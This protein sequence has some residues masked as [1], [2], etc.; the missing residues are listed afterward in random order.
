MPFSSLLAGTSL[1]KPYD[2]SPDDRFLLL[3]TSG[4]T[5]NPKGVPHAQRGFLANADSSVAELEMSKG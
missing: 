4:T 5:D 2:G 3:Y 1:Q